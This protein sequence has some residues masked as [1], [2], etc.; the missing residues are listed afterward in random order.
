V[1][2]III[3]ILLII[4]VLVAFG[5]INQFDLIDWK[6]NDLAIAVA[7]LAGPFQFLRKKMEEKQDDEKK[8]ERELAFRKISY[9]QIKN[10]EAQVKNQSVALDTPKEKSEFEIDEPTFG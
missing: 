7:A 4:V 2:N 9:D 3:V 8:F 6:W 5:M 1:K 10:R